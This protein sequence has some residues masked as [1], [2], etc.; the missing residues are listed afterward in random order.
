MIII[1]I[2]CKQIDQKL[3]SLISTTTTEILK[4]F[5]SFL[6]LCLEKMHTMLATFQLNV[7]DFY[8]KTKSLYII[9]FKV[10]LMD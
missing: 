2:Y 4:E 10:E 1:C 5:H 8:S 6:K 7:W 3:I 9:R